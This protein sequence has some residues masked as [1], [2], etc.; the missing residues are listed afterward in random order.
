MQARSQVLRFGEANYILG[1][2]D[3][4]FYYM[5]ETNFSGHKKIW[6]AHKK[7]GGHCPRNPPRGYGPGEMPMILALKRFCC[8]VQHR[9][10]NNWYFLF[11]L[12]N[13]I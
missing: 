8:N 3:F 6:G 5:F 9:R 12:F 13:F 7:L 11:I 10:G 2:Q 1:W 4:S